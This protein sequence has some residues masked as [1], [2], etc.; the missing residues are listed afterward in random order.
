MNNA[1]DINQL[2]CEGGNLK[3]SIKSVL[4]EKK[5]LRHYFYKPFKETE[6]YI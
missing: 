1:A 5:F 2:V 6:S 4:F 3:I